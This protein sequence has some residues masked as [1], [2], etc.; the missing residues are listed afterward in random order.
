MAK[1]KA[2]VPK[3]SFEQAGIEPKE[4]T[5]VSLKAQDGNVIVAEVAEVS[6]DHVVCTYDK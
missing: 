1:M 2:A 3:A 5:K 6:K 4:G